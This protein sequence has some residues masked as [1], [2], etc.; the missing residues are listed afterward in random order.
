METRE[1]ETLHIPKKNPAVWPTVLHV[2][3]CPT[4]HLFNIVKAQPSTAISCVA[5]KKFNNR[6]D[7]VSIVIEGGSPSIPSQSVTQYDTIIIT[8]PIKYWTGTS[9]VFLLPNSGQNI[10]STIG[11]H[12]SFTLKGQ[13]TKL[14]SACCVYVMPL[15]CKSI[16]TAPAN[17][18]GIPCN[19]YRNNKTAM[20]SSSPLMLLL[21]SFGASPF[22]INSSFSGEFLRFVKVIIAALIALMFAVLNQD[23]T[24]NKFF[25]L[26]TD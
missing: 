14:N 20:F 7:T 13:F 22:S 16:G 5:A 18:S 19:V 25:F 21:P 4:L 12:N 11:A 8:I 10:A 24:E 6:K 15:F 3:A 1:P 23:H 2:E 17:P 26:K 9:Q